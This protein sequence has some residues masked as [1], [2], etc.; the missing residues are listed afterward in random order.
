MEAFLIRLHKDNS[1]PDATLKI[2]I[3][4]TSIY[5]VFTKRSG[6]PSMFEPSFILNQTFY[7][8]SIFNPIDGIGPDNR[9][10]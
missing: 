1:Y 6:R 4:L 3:S 2:Y 8:T 5:G 7:E 10:E 9:C